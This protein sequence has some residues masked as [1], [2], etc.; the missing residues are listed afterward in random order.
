MKTRFA[1]GKHGIE[2]SVPSG[3][4]CHVAHTRAAPALANVSAALA[5]A[6]DDPIRCEPLTRMAAGKRTAAISVCDITRPAPNATTLPPLLERLHR[7]GIPV[8][9][10]TILIATGLHRGATRDEL[11]VIL[12]PEIA[13]KYRVVSHDAR[14]F[15][16]HRALGTSS[17]GTP[18]YVDERFMAADLHISLGFVEQH[19]MLGFSGGRKLVVPGLAAQETIKVIHSPRFMRE[20]MATEGSIDSN[21]LHAELVE[22]AAMARHDFI[23]DVTLTREREISGVFAGNPVEAHA[24]AVRF[25]ETTSTAPV[26]GLADAVITSAAGYPLDMTFYQSVKGITAA[27]HIV[28]PGGR[29]LVLGECAEGIGSDEFARMIRNYPGHTAFLDEIRETRVEVDQWQL[30]K[31][32][33]VG[34]KNELFFYTPGVEPEALGSLAPRTFGDLDQAVAALLNGL[35]PDALVLLVPEGPYTYARPLPVL[36]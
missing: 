21:P 26:P 32:A 20:P 7:A 2:V 34:V 5:A 3:F 17:R 25:L 8:D 23:L 28:K 24:A 18:V 22:A 27:Q 13:A 4:D 10:V 15:A 1:F 9:G 29:I 16:A 11:D 36:A 35:P 19:L 12:G 30:E 6:L 14:D 33:L 31:L